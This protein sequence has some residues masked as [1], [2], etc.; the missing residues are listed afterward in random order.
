[1]KDNYAASQLAVSVTGDAI[2]FNVSLTCNGNKVCNMNTVLKGDSVRGIY[3]VGAYFSKTGT[4]GYIP[5]QWTVQ[6]RPGAS[7]DELHLDF[8]PV[9]NPNSVATEFE[10]EISFA[11]DEAAPAMFDENFPSG[12]TLGG[13]AINFPRVNIV[14]KVDE[15]E[16][17]VTAK[18][19]L[20]CSVKA[21][22]R[23]CR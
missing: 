10:V 9:R 8:G 19:C 4:M 20:M 15:A 14:E 22:R 11:V 13:A 2:I 21:M 6:S 18:S 17:P 16:N 23:P 3:P 7:T 12:S 5:P 1:M